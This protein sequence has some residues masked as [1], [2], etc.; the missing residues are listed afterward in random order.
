MG[1]PL[2]VPALSGIAMIDGLPDQDC[3][4]ELNFGYY[5]YKEKLRTRPRHL[6][7]EDELCPLIR[8]M[9][10]RELLILRSNDSNMVS[11]HRRNCVER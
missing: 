11:V 3:K 7:T 10:F 1:I 9:E 6:L 5:A 4:V 2:V 8:A